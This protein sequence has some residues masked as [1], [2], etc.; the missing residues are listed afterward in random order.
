MLSGRVHAG[1]TGGHPI[2]VEEMD[3]YQ[4]DMPRLARVLDVVGLEGRLLQ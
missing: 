4:Y 1:D 3:C 2:A